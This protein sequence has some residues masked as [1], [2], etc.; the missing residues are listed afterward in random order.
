MASGL[1]QKLRTFGKSILEANS[2]RHHE[3]RF[4][5]K[6]IKPADK[7]LDAGCGTGT[8]LDTLPVNEKIGFDLNSDNVL[9]CQEKGLSVRE[10][11]VLDIPFVNDSFDVVH[12]SHV[13]QVFSNNDAAQMVQELARVTKPKGLIIISTLNW[14]SRFYRHP[15]NARPYPPDVFWRYFGRQ[16]GESSPMFPDMPFCRIEKIWLRRPALVEFDFSINKDLAGV[17]HILNVLQYKFFL[18]K[19]WAYNSYIIILQKE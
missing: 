3:Y 17:G 6:Y 13:M 15:E 2:L 1:W 12:C 8:F 14:F 16:E 9:Y 4:A 7:V 18:R 5:R 19:F 10:G 11:S